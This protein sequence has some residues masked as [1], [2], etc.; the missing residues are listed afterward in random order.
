MNPVK[1]NG[2]RT[3]GYTLDR[4]TLYSVPLGENEYGH[5]SFDTKRTELGELLYRMKYNGN[6]DTSLEILKLI[7]PF[8]DNWLLDKDIDFV[9]PMPPTKKRKL[10]PVFAIAYA[11]A[12]HYGFNYDFAVF[13]KTSDIQAKDMTESNKSLNGCIEMVKHATKPHNV[14]LVDDLYQTE[15]TAEECVRLLRDDN[16]I[17]NIYYLALTRSKR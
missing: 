15:S 17:N 2:S 14:L 8:L 9:I 12:K 10:Q 3:E 13:K 6:S 11:I 4:H 1:V 16:N 7:L 5:M